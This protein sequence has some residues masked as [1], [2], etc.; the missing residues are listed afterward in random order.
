M[1]GYFIGSA[2]PDPKTFGLDAIFPAIL[3]ALTFN[4]LKNKSTRKAAF[5]GSTLALMTTPFLASG[6]PI[7]D[8]AFWLNMG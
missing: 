3:I 4:A 7:P 6:L 2:I 8:F 5:A 1:A